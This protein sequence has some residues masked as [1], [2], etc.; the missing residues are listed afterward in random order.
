MGGPVCRPYVL[1]RFPHGGRPQGSPLRRIQKPSLRFVGAGHWPARG[2]GNSLSPLS[3]C[4]RHLPLIRGVVPSPTRGTHGFQFAQGS[5]LGLPPHPSRFA[6]HLP[7]KGKAGGCHLKAFPFRGRCPR[8]GRMRYPVF[9]TRHVG[10]ATP[11]AV[12]ESHQL[13]FSKNPGPSGPEESAESHSDFARRKCFAW[14]KG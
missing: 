12:V 11:G 9:R 6:C 7:L 10:S 8:R 4:A 2:R 3:R 14:L 5:P 13:Q 1:K